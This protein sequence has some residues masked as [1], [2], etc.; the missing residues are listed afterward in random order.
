MCVT[1]AGLEREITHDV[2]GF[3]RCWHGPRVAIFVMNFFASIKLHQQSIQMMQR[4]ERTAIVLGVFFR[5]GFLQKIP[6]TTT[7][8]TQFWK[9]YI[10]TCCL[11]AQL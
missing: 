11:K 3:W 10:S 8:E 7:Y 6:A 9:I 5:L 4:S 1:N 2:L